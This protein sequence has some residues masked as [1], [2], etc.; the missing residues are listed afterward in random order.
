ME[1]DPLARAED[2][3]SSS[4]TTRHLAESGRV[5]PVHFFSL[6]SLSSLSSL[7][8]LFSLFS[9]PSRLSLL[10]LLSFCSFFATPAARYATSLAVPTFRRYDT[11]RRHGGCG[12]TKLQQAVLSTPTRTGGPLA[13]FR[14]SL[15]RLSTSNLHSA[16]MRSSNHAVAPT[17]G[18]A[19]DRSADVGRVAHP[20]SKR[21]SDR[22]GVVLACAGGS[23]R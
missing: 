19:I 11:F 14:T 3:D 7:F 20:L 10:S 17:R 21:T 15:V 16:G 12:H 4:T 23:G 22:F 9:L 18:E 2:R 1:R 5:L 6:S 13:S 8:S